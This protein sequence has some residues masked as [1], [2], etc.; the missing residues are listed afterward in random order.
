MKELII[1]ALEAKNFSYSPYSKFS[2]GAALQTADGKVF[3]G[4]N[5]E[6]SAFSPTVCAERTAFVKALSEGERSF[7][8][9]A[10]VS[11][12][13]KIIT[14]CGVCRQFIREFCS[15]DFKIICALDT[16]NYKIFSLEELLPHSFILGEKL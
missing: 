1:K 5:I 2:V 6:N 7:K 3:T 13:D 15:E 10:I 14:P 11:S 4:C 9:I 16:E 12:S 8:A